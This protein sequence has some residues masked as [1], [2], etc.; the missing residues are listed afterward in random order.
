MSAE[1]IG[2]SVFVASILLAI[3]FLGCGGSSNTFRYL[4]TAADDQS[5][6][7][8][9]DKARAQFD[10]GHLHAALE[11]SAEALRLNKKSEKAAVL[12]GFVNLALAG[13]DPFRLAKA[14]TQSL[15][16]PLTSGL[17]E[18]QVAEKISIASDMLLEQ[19]Q[20]DP[21]V[22]LQSAIGLMPEE[23][24][25]LGDLDQEVPELPLILPRCAENVRRDVARLRHLDFA[26]IAICPFIDAE[27]KVPL[28]YRQNCEAT[29]SK[30]AKTDEAHFLWSFAHLAEALIFN[31]VL[32]YRGQKSPSSLTHLESR[33][34]RVNGA[35]SAGFEKLSESINS[36]RKITDRIMPIDDHCG[37][38]TPTSQL[39]AT[40]MD[41]MAVG[42][43]FAN[44]P[45]LPQKMIN[46]LRKGLSGF[47]QAEASLITMR[48]NLTKNISQEFSRKVDQLASEQVLNDNER[49]S[50]CNQLGALAVGNQILP[51]AC[52]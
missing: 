47:A 51:A 23:I 49:A 44:L 2:S 16:D 20:G 33:A 37:P 11:S 31:A 15:S 24:L 38:G 19:N 9:L 52:K 5:F 13:A 4:K 8:V 27:A 45:H 48:G 35:N 3:T 34:Q 30:K 40:L 12:F 42:R 43:G 28:D 7:Y 41:L 10:A 46:P 14:L 25:Q 17:R 50:I 6:D 1:G 22:L 36:I 21:L 26:I 32:T 29:D 39:K 18:K